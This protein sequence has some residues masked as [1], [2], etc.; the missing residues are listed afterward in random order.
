MKLSLEERFDSKIEFD[1]PSGC[2]NWTAAKDRDG[3]G[4]FKVQG[5]MRRAHRIAWVLVNGPI[6]NEKVIDHKCSNRACV[7]PDHMRLAS[8][9]ENSRNVRKTCGGVYWH[10]RDLRWIAQINL[11]RK[12]I[13]LGSFVSRAEALLVRQKAELELFGEFANL[14][15]KCF[16]V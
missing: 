11:N 1:G 5:K 14:G 12:K 10:K 4:L 16:S 2:W 6:P 15:E 9:A 7:N 8:Y 3:Y 13:H